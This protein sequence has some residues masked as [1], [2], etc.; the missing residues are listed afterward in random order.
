MKSVRLWA[1]LCISLLIVGCATGP[2]IKSTQ[3]NTKKD[4]SLRIER[5]Q[6]HEAQKLP[7][8][9]IFSGSGGVLP[10][11][12]AW[13]NAFYAADF[14]AIIVDYIGSRGLQ[15]I[16]LN[17]QAIPSQQVALD[18]HHVAEW[19]TKQ[20]WSNGRVGMIGFS[21]GARGAIFAASKKQALQDFGKPTALGA[22]VAA[23]PG[24]PS[25]GWEYNDTVGI[26]LHIHF[27]EADQWVGQGPSVCISFAEE[28]KANVKL[29]LYPGAHHAYDN[30]ANSPLKYLP[31]GYRTTLGLGGGCAVEYNEAAYQNTMKTALELFNKEL[32]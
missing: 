9:L 12:Y 2:E 24:C 5:M 4:I 29:F 16:T 19:V 30:P 32:R 14:N 28:N 3:L 26:P 6:I 1:L 7:T 22:A 10:S 11:E 15:R 13:M 27:A 18:A 23:Y 8:I 17:T 21:W 25:V 31:C 20:P